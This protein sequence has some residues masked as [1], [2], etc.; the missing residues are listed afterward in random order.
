MRRVLT[1]AVVAIGAG[2]L[3]A[4][5]E[6]RMRP[7]TPQNQLRI[8]ELWREPHNIAAQNL[9]D[10][11]WGHALAPDPDASYRFRRSERIGVNPG[12]TVVDSSG[13]EWNIKQA[14]HYGRL[15]EGPLEVVLSRVLSAV[16]YHQPPV[17]FLPAFTLKDTFGT[18]Q[19]AGGRFRLRPPELS[20]RET[21]DWRKNPFVGTRPYNGLLVILA[22]FDSA[23]LKSANNRVYER[24]TTPGSVERWYVV[25]DLGATLA[26][27]VRASTGDSERFAAFPFHTGT[28]T[29]YVQFAHTGRQGDLLRDRITPDDVRWA[30]QLLARLTD[31]QWR[32]AFRAGGYGQADVDRFTQRLRDQVSEGLTMGA[33]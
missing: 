28:D 27:R 30:C 3:V 24:T 16:G 2:L 1:L 12:M 9:F 11:P 29:G 19:E 14:P 18:R 5:S 8:E 26:S 7:A 6:A 13:R 20:E 4:G 17:Y 15:A 32:D 33:D 31:A 21:W 22:M 10:G 25:R 23:D